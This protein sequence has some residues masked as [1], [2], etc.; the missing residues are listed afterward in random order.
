MG[1]HTILMDVACV[2]LF[3]SYPVNIAIILSHKRK[4]GLISGF[5]STSLP[6]LETLQ[7]VDVRTASVGH[8]NAARR[9]VAVQLTG[10]SRFCRLRRH[11]EVDL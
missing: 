6:R 1:Q 5:D 8:R 7:L 4:R 9:A 3:V 11:L 10:T 2:T